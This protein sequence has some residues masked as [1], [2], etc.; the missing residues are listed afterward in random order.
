MIFATGAITGIH[1]IGPGSG[2]ASKCGVDRQWNSGPRTAT[3]W[4]SGEQLDVDARR[5]VGCSE[6][7]RKASSPATASPHRSRPA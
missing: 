6:R 1:P 2:A 3:R 5:C 4:C 7:C